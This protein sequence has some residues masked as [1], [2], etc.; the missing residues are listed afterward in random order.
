M[1]Q[2]TANMSALEW[3]FRKPSE[4]NFPQDTSSPE[5]RQL[6]KAV[7][8]LSIAIL[9]QPEFQ[10]ASEHGRFFA[11]WVTKIDNVARIEKADIN[12][13]MQKLSAIMEAVKQ[14]KRS[15][16]ADRFNAAVIALVIFAKTSQDIE[17][18]NAVIAL[19]K[20][21]VSDNSNSQ[22][23]KITALA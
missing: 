13:L 11:Q 23:T 6:S 9:D 20:G 16:I 14:S 15:K 18:R 1:L 12:S 17:F 21:M 5:L 8:Q 3:F 19:A 7:D 10:G 22:E 2:T 4:S